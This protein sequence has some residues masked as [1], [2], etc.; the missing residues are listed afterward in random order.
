MPTPVIGI[1]LYGPTAKP[2]DAS[3]EEKYRAL[4]EQMAGQQWTVRT[5]TYH[6]DVR[7]ALRAE[8][9]GC[10]AVLVWINPI[11]PR[12][13]RAALDEF[14]RELAAAGVLVSA[15]PDAILKI[16]T[17]DVLVAT[18]A[19]SW[20]ADARAYRSAPEFQEQFPARVRRD[21]IRVLKQYRGNGGQ[22]VWKVFVDSGDKFVV[23]SATRGAPAIHLSEAALFDFFQTEVFANRS[24]LVDQQWVPTLNRGMIRAYLC[25]TKVAGFGYQEINA[26]YPVAPAD[27]SLRAQ[28]SPR[29]YYTEQC[30]LFARLR[31]RLEREWLPAFQAHLQM[32][33][34]EFPLLWDADFFLADPPREFLL[35]EINASCVSP[36]PPSAVPHLIAELKQRLAS[37]TPGKLR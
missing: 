29:H 3:T 25:G 16:G 28:P 11:E 19:L 5:L 20:S 22:G 15:H 27:D 31:E 10:D 23:Q 37:R 6:D 30:F 32:T 24:H 34:V 18:Q 35:C 36:F 4:V 33:D 7:D 21:G 17:K 8:A 14:L 12:L 1:L 13:N 2:R 9:R 26:L